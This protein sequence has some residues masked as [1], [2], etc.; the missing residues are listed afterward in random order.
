MAAVSLLGPQTRTPG[1]QMLIGG[2]PNYPIHTD[3][4]ERA[5]VSRAQ[6]IGAR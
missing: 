6:V 4:C 5:A 1:N 2:L 3:A